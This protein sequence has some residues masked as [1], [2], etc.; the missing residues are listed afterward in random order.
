MTPDEIA[1]LEANIVDICQAHKEEN[2]RKVGFRLCV[3]VEPCNVVKHGHPETLLPEISTQ[4]YIFDYAESQQDASCVPRIP[5]IKHHFRKE[6][7]MYLVMERITLT[8]PPFR[9]HR[10]DSSGSQRRNLLPTM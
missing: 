5:K 9:L 6:H 1:T 2:C 10:E 7:T 8:V 3:F 4:Q